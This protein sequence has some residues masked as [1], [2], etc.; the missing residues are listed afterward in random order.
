MGLPL[1]EGLM[2]DNGL[3][4]LAAVQRPE[5]FLKQ[6]WAI[7]EGGDQVQSAINRL[8]R[9]G[10]TY[11]LQKKIIVDNQPVLEIYRR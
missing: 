7:V 6:E 10:I 1:R 3:P 2:V 4:W 8:G 5:F 9:F 11:T